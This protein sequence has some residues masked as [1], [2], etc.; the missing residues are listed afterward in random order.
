MAGGG[1]S[2]HRLLA[3]LRGYAQRLPA[4]SDKQVR[5]GA[6]RQPPGTGVMKS[7]RQIIQNC[8]T[9]LADLK[10]YEPSFH[11][12]LAIVQITDDGMLEVKKMAEEVGLHVVHICLPEETA[13][14]EILDEITK[15]NED[16]KI[17][18]LVLPR[19]LVMSDAAIN[20]LVPEKDVDG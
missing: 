7:V 14:E 18:G 9:E 19:S 4:L 11:P 10:K 3:G 5:S 12:G 8:K 6:G 17:Q 15:L 20:T 16:P 13:T 2:W 1:L